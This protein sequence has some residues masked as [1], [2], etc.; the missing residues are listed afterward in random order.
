MAAGINE[1]RIGSV[2]D[3][4][5]TALRRYYREELGKAAIRADHLVGRTLFMQAT[6]GGEKGDWK[7]A[8]PACT[9]FWAKTR[10]GYRVPD[11]WGEEYDEEGRRVIRVINSPETT[12]LSPP[13][14][15]GGGSNGDG[16]DLR[17]RHARTAR[18]AQSMIATR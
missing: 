5:E 3:I 1:T 13:R 2:L 11:S 18:L 16:S 10:M 12:R 9:I 15:N 8:V 6:G 14:P 7:Q 17:N 4:G